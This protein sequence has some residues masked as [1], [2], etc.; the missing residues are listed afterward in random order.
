MATWP[1][2]LPPPLVG[3]LTIVPERNIVAWQPEVGRPLKRRRYT[4][5]RDRVAFAILL[6]TG[7]MRDDLQ[8]FFR[9]DCEDGTV[10]FT[11][12]DPDTGDERTFSWEAEPQIAHVGL[13]I[14]RAAISLAREP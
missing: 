11:M 14:Y 1:A 4:A 9:D 7:A 10:T 12:D 3:T 8:E 13:E 6:T 2:S 5:K